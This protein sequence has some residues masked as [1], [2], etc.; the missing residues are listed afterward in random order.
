MADVNRLK[1][2]PY[3]HA[4]YQ[5]KQVLLISPQVQKLQWQSRKKIPN[6]LPLNVARNDG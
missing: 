3:S 5:V 6:E 2:L 1:T 4:F